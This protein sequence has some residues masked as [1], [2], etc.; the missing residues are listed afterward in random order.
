MEVDG[1][2]QCNEGYVEVSGNCQ[3]PQYHELI[4]GKCQCLPT[5]TASGSDCICGLHQH[6]ESNRC[7][8]DST[9]KPSSSQP[10]QCECPSGTVLKGSTC[11]RCT[12]S[13]HQHINSAGLC[14]C[15]EGYVRD[16]QGN[17]ACPNREQEVAGVCQC[18]PTFHRWVKKICIRNV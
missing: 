9:F 13:A 8:C 18:I 11:V 5:F 6:V 12:N 4:N 17:C 10:S 3:C 14:E 15:D 16:S 7:V 1:V 2:C